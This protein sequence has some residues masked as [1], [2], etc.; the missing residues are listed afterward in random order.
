MSEHQSPIP[1]VAVSLYFDGSVR[2][3]ADGYW[4][5]QIGW[6]A[7]AF[8]AVRLFAAG[9]TKL[10]PRRAHNPAQA[11]WEALSAGLEW[12]CR[13][14]SLERVTIYG[15]AQSVIDS[16]N[17]GGTKHALHV[18]QNCVRALSELGVPFRASW[19][20]REGNGLADR[21]SRCTPAEVLEIAQRLVP[22]A[23]PDPPVAE[24]NEHLTRALAEQLWRAAGCPHG[25]DER[26]W[27]A[28]ENFLRAARAS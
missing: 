26:F 28:A 7:V 27:F 8:G 16:V 22:P 14:R 9:S 19:I 2:T 12:V 15:D 25:E 17:K 5:P 3:V 11:E 18:A 1:R 24:P 10:K 23:E 4:E 13:L 20:P 21:L 6:L